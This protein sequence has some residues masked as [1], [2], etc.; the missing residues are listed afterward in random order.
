MR[1]RGAGLLTLLAALSASCSGGATTPSTP[2][3]GT[4]Y[5][6]ATVKLEQTF[7]LDLDT[8]TF[9]PGVGVGADIWFQALTDQ[10]RYLTPARSQGAALAVTGET[11]PGFSGCA[12]ARLSGAEI[13]IESLTTGLYLCASTSEGRIAEIRIVEP[14]GPSGPAAALTISYTTYNR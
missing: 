4:I 5:R 1:S 14:A 8:G 2:M 13:P 11:S 9:P 10:L 7:Q 3:A 12:A 6:Q